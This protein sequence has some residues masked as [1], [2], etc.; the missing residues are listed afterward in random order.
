VSKKLASDVAQKMFANDGHSQNLDM[1]L[2]D[3]DQGF[4]VMQLVISS[5][6]VN[7]HGTA[8]GGVIFSLADTAF[9]HACN[10][11]NQVAVAQQCDIS[12]LAPA[13]IDDCLKARAKLVAEQGRTGI[14]DV[15]VTNQEQQTIAIFHGQS[16]TIKGQVL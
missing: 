15:I 13:F 8:H 6:H 4:S 14:Y 16:R 12:Y 10:S 2:I 7:G 9:A 5:K 1:T 3:A 11:K